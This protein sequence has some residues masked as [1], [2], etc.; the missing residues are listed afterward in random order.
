VVVLIVALMAALIADRLAALIAV[1]RAAADHLAALIAAPRAVAAAVVLTAVPRVA[2]A[3]VRIAVPT[4]AVVVAA[5]IVA[6]MAALIAD[7]P[8]APTVARLAAAA[9]AAAVLIVGGQVATAVAVLEARQVAVAPNGQRHG[10]P[11]APLAAAVGPGFS[12]RT[13]PRVRRAPLHRAP[14]PGGSATRSRQSRLPRPPLTTP[15][16]RSAPRLPLPDSRRG[17]VSP[18]PSPTTSPWSN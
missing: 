10:A 3:V 4:A 1:P 9:A 13:A 7:R 17:N 15:A 16:R 18:W 6:L 11:A 14:S 2:V 8:V 12:S 5:L